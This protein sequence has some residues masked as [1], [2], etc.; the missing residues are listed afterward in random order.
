MKLIF[1]PRCGDIIALRAER[2]TCVCGASYGQ[3]L[4]DVNAVYGGQAIPLGIANQS[5]AQAVRHQPDHGQGQRF[6]AFVIPKICPTM[7]RVG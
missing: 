5:F 4:D 2:R 7:T 6:D 1:C 3:Y